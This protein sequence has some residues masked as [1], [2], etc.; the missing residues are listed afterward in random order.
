MES[1]TQKAAA[2]A[3]LHDIDA[4]ASARRTIGDY[5]VLELLGKG[6]FGTVYKVRHRR[7]GGQCAMKLLAQGLSGGELWA[8]TPR[9]P[10]TGGGRPRTAARVEESQAAAMAQEVAILS[11]LEHPHIVH[12]YEQVHCE[13]GSLA[14]VMEYVE[15]KASLGA[16]GGVHALAM[17]QAIKLVAISEAVATDGVFA[18]QARRRFAA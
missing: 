12:Y 9:R 14:I 10:Q 1:S 16:S 11:Q 17:S 8:S 7:L 2:E 3:A 18:R 15:V 13:D 5:D 4:K 6:A